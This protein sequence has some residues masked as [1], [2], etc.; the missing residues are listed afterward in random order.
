MTRH[1][2]FKSSVRARMEKTG[3]RYAVARAA[4]LSSGPEGSSL[5]PSTTPSSTTPS[6]RYSVRRGLTGDLARLTSALEAVGVVDPFT[7]APYSET[8]VM[9]LSGGVGFMAFLFLYDGHPPML[10]LTCRHFSMPAPLVDRMLAVSGIDVVTHQ[11][12]SAKKA[13]ATL[14]EILDVDAAAGN[15]GLGVAHLSVDRATLPWSGQDSIWQGQWPS[16]VN[17]LRR[18]GEL[19]MDDGGVLRAITAA[20]LATARASVKKEKHRLFEFRGRESRTDPV[21][22]TRQAVLATSTG[23]REAPFKGFANNFGLAGLAK[24]QRAMGDTRDPRGW[25]TVFSSGPLVFGALWRVWEC[26][27]LELTAPAGGRAMY[28]DFLEARSTLPGLEGLKGSAAL[29]HESALAFEALA[30]AVTSTGPAPFQA[31]MAQAIAASEEMEAI[32]HGDG[33]THGDAE[34]FPN[35]WVVDVDTSIAHGNQ[36]ATARAVRASLG[37]DVELSEGER[38][39]IFGVLGEKMAAIVT[40]E[41]ALADSLAAALGMV[42]P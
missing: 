12:G 36:V 8:S 7:G 39:E 38:L 41:T 15:T 10:T 27:M 35:G 33:G 40:A 28:A 37:D 22:A 2:R 3:E 29:A 19:V 32:A 31:L 34:G 4:L 20:Q 6:S 42:G 11:T 24:V 23:Y 5:T 1:A 16:H 21:E 9:G 17:V 26:L 30:E 18:D 14:E 25:P 13:A